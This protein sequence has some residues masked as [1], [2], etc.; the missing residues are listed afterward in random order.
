MPRRR[1]PASPDLQF[2]ETRVRKDTWAGSMLKVGLRPTCYT[3]RVQS[4]RRYVGAPPLLE[5][6]RSATGTWCRTHR[7]VD[8]L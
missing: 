4:Q 3:S 2:R 7:N 6:E 5:E 1:S 8:I